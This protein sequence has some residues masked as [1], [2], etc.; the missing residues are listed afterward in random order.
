MTKQPETGKYQDT[1]GFGEA[2][3]KGDPTGGKPG[4]EHVEMP[5]EKAA[6]IAAIQAKQNAAAAAKGGTGGGKPE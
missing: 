3:G 6:A 4:V 5:A 2:T 1:E